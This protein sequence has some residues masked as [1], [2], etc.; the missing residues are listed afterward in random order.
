MISNLYYSRIEKYAVDPVKF[1]IK[2]PNKPDRLLLHIIL[3]FCYVWI[4]P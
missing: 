2:V 1:V 3:N 4:L